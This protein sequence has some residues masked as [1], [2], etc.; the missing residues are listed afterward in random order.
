MNYYE[1]LNV[2]QSATYEEIKRAYHKLARI[3]HPDKNGKKEDFQKIQ[4]AYQVLSDEEHRK[5]YDVWLLNNNGDLNIPFLEKYPIWVKFYPVLVDLLSNY[6]I[7]QELTIG[8]L[9]TYLKSKIFDIETGKIILRFITELITNNEEKN[10]REITINCTIDEIYKDKS[11]IFHMDKEIYKVSLL[12]E[13]YI[14]DDIKFKR[15]VIEHKYLE[16]ENHNLRRKIDVSLYEWMRGGEWLIDHPYGKNIRIRQK[17]YITGECIE[18][19]GWGLPKIEECGEAPN[20][21][22]GDLIVEFSVKYDKEKLKKHFPIFNKIEKS[23]DDT[24][25]IDLDS[26]SE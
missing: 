11:K 7:E 18:L 22:Y 23:N 15:N 12:N 6:P 13:E 3:N 19:A 5:N 16:V 8:N 17:G 4:E 24:K 10:M 9:V 2:S 21:N 1:I 14:I 26:D 25:Y 20:E